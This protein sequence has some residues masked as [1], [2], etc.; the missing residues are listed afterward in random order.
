MKKCVVC[1]QYK[2]FCVKCFKQIYRTKED[3]WICSECLKKELQIK[4]GGKD[5]SLL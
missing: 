5:R 2:A 3:Q 1:K 4:E